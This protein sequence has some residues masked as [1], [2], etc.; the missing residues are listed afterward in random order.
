VDA[1]DG[2]GLGPSQ[3]YAGGMRPVLPDDVKSASDM[4]AMGDSLPMVKWPYIY[5]FILAVGDGSRPAQE[6][7]NGGSNISFADGHVSSYP[8]QRLLENSD[9]ARRRWNK[10]HE[11]H[12][13]I[14]LP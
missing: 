7:H 13:E 10:D 6:R 3:S 2:L 14:P 5:G 1:A 12:P 11:P 8:N 9:V 4:I